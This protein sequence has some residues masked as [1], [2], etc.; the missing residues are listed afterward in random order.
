M[1]RSL[2]FPLEPLDRWSLGLLG[3]CAVLLLI[4]HRTFLPF[5]PDGYYHLMV[6]QQMV[7]TWRVPFWDA[8]QFAPEG[9]PHLY[10]PL[11]HILLAL[12]SAPFGGD[13]LEAFRLT[14]AYLLP[15]ALFTAWYAARWMFGP[16][17]AFMAL[18][19]LGWDPMFVIMGMM[20]LPSVL[21]GAMVCLLII[22]FLARRLTLACV[23]AIAAFYT[24]LGL[25]PF[26]LLALFLFCLWQRD[27]RR[28]F[29]VLVA[30]TVIAIAPWYVRFFFYRDWLHH[31]ID[32]GIYGWYEGWARPLMKMAWLQ[33][34]NLG[35][36]ALAVWSLRKLPRRDPRYRLILAGIVGFLPM[37][38]SY[39]GRYYAHSV[40]LW[41]MLAGKSLER[42][43][44]PR[45]IA[46]ALCPTLVLVG[47]GT[48]V[49][50]GVI[51]MASG[52]CFPP[53]LGLGGMTYL[54][55]GARLGLV[56]YHDA[57]ALATRIQHATTPDTILHLNGDRDLGV[58]IGFLA[59]RRIDVGA[60]EEVS[61]P[62]FRGD[63][64]GG[65]SREGCYV[66]RDRS[67]I[68]RHMEVEEV[69]SLW[70]GRPK[71]TGPQ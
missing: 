2:W 52:W 46:F 36:V 5:P 66:S 50:P 69:G 40:P 25:G 32:L 16:R 1:T 39:G 54:D 8:W 70:W 28:P 63:R 10:P 71:P 64:A 51:P 45:A 29:A 12:L 26:A 19:L 3:L 48:V 44:R 47:Y 4:G 65:V 14:L 67:G 41:A 13:V 30:V 18:L 31:P 38:F 23:A 49:G 35:M 17:H 34:I 11:F 6:A 68:P 42:F 37:L 55:G 7:D 33:F 43:A 15:F 56:S 61:P 58:M 24:H 62:T 20:G 27:Y 53:L 57:K 9:R 22:F 60:W 21:S 59:H